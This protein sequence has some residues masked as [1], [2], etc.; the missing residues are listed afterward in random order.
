M[1]KYNIKY[2]NGTYQQHI[3]YRKVLEELRLFKYFLQLLTSKL[4][5]PSIDRKLMVTTT[6]AVYGN[7]SNTLILRSHFLTMFVYYI[8]VHVLYQQSATQEQRNSHVSFSNKPQWSFY[9]ID[10]TKNSCMFVSMFLC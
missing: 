6:I 8:H 3:C 10:G 1:C 9:N 5:G 4:I 7:N 2:G